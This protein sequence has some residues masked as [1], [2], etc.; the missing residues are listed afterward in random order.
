MRRTVATKKK[1]TEHGSLHTDQS[2]ADKSGD[3]K[4]DAIEIEHDECDDNSDNEPNEYWIR[5]ETVSLNMDCKIAIETGQMLDDRVILAAQN[6]LKRQFPEVNGFQ[7]SVLS[8][9]DITFEACQNNMVQ[10]L[11]KGSSK[12]GHWLTISTLNLKPGYVN[13]YDSLNL[14]L[15]LD[16]TNQICTILR[17]ESTYVTAN[18]VPM[19]QQH[20]NE[21]CGLF[22]VATAVALCCGHEPNKILFRQDLLRNHLINCLEQG[23]FS[24]FPFDV[25]VR[26][27]KIKTQKIR[28]HCK[29]R[30][31]RDGTPMLK[32]HNCC[33]W[34]H[35]RCIESNTDNSDAPFFC[36]DFCLL[37]H[38]ENGNS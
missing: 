11:F 21:D 10:I 3:S 18:K 7:P 2:Q 33:E 23:N 38:R 30:R 16:V 36:S 17:Q 24:M 22:A 32:C 28:V 26:Q 14:D 19:Q 15:D 20:G 29:C 6:I 34:F 8:Q 4:T 25:N 37:E 12:C 31:P 35:S 9:G 1:Q 5:N 27:K 13:V